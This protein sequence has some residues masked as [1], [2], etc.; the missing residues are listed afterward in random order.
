[1]HYYN[2]PPFSVGE[3]RPL[4]GPG[5]REVGHGALAE[6]AL[7][8][9]V[10][11]EDDFPYTIHVVSE[12]L[13]SNGS[14]SMASVC[15]STLA[16]MDAGVPIKAPVAGIAMGLITDG[17]K[18]KILTDIQGVEDSTGDMD[19]KVTGTVNG[20]TALQMDV[21]LEKIS[22]EIIKEGLGKAKT[23]RLFILNKITEVISKPRENLSAYAPRIQIIK[24][25]PEKIG[26]L[27]GPQGKVIKKI[28]EITGAKIEIEPDGKV[29]ISAPNETSIQAALGEIKEITDEV[30]IGKV[31]KGK[32][33]VI[34][35]YGAFVELK[36][37]KDG[38]LHISQIS[39]K[40]ISKV[41]EALSLG[42]EILVKV[43]KIDELGRVSLTMKDI[44]NN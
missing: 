26:E 43:I 32:V 1:M 42:Q 9:M 25:N 20:I 22:F 18:Y 40:R 34:R 13:E 33:I 38:L 36:K 16:L 12:I 4:R 8:Q 3:V 29:F 30:E 6:R 37:G 15:G 23:A 39:D 31:Y 24:I 7:L 21:K 44:E 11:N 27:I 10:P 2:F 14:S 5:R 41:E 19:F 17:E 28:I 35:D